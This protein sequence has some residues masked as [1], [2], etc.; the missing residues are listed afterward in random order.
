MNR[1]PDDRPREHY[2]RFAHRVFPVVLFRNT[3][4][5]RGAALAGRAEGGLQRM[6]EDVATRTGV[7]SDASLPVRASLHECHGRAVVVVTPPKPEHVTEAH[8]IAVVLDPNDAAFL[9]YVVLEHSW[10]IHSQ[11]RTAI[12]EWTAAESHINYGDGP[13]PTE[14]AFLAVICDKFTDVLQ[15]RA[16]AS[17]G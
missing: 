8:F 13:E 5:F 14:A 1:F 12:G 16:A 9:R 7:P 3:E 2:Y 10:D 6:W 4:P 15:P 17:G 11:P